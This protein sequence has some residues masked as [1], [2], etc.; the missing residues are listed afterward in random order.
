MSKLGMEVSWRHIGKGTLIHFSFSAQ[1][2]GHETDKK[3]EKGIETGRNAERI[4]YV[5]KEGREVEGGDWGVT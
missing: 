3:M 5:W 4:E 1:K 2:S